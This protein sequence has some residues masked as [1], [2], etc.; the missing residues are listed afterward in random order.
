MLQ[1]T[2][3]NMS[4]GIS[5]VDE[6]LHMTAMNEK[7][8]EVLDFPVEMARSGASFEAFVRYNAERGDYGPCDVDS[9]VRELLAF[10]DLAHG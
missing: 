9:K 8:C 3:D 5:V 4:Q 10:A 1:A 7:F 2:L 6:S